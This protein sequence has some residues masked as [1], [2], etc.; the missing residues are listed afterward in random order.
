MSVSIE[1]RKKYKRD[2][3]YD[4]KVQMGDAR[5]AL[6]TAMALVRKAERRLNKM[7]ELSIV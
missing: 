7:K 1:I 5:V 2:I 4:I 6:N 3:V